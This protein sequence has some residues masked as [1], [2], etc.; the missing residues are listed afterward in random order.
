MAALDDDHLVVRVVYTGPPQAGKTQSVRALMPLLRGKGANHAVMSPGEWRGRTAFFDWADYE[1][2]VYD[3]KPIRCQILSTPGQVALSDRRELLLRA[4]D[5]VILVVDSRQ[6]AIERAT[7]CY[8]E[9]APWLADAGRDEPIRVILQCN[10][11][12][13]PGA[14][15]AADLSR[16][17]GVPCGKDVYATSA[18][19][20]K[21]LRAAFVAGVRNAVDRARALVARGIPLQPPEVL[22][23]QELFERMR[24]KVAPIGAHVPANARVAARSAAGVAGAAA[25]QAAAAASASTST[26]GSRASKRPSGTHAAPAW[27]WASDSEPPS[28]V[29]RQSARPSRSGSFPASGSLRPRASDPAPG[30]AARVPSTP[31]TSPPTPASASPA[32]TPKRSGTSAVPRPQP[33]KPNPTRASD[34]RARSSKEAPAPLEPS[35]A[36]TSRVAAAPLRPRNAKLSREPPA[37]HRSA[38]T[39]AAQNHSLAAELAAPQSHSLAAK[40]PV[41]RDHSPA[42]RAPVSPGQSLAAKAAHGASAQPVSR[43][44]PAS[45]ASPAPAR[46]GMAEARAPSAPLP[47]AVA[48]ARTESATLPVPVHDSEPASSGRRAPPPSS[49][50][51]QPESEAHPTVAASARALPR[52]VVGGVRPAVM[53]A[54]AYFAALARSASDAGEAQRE[55]APGASHD[56]GAPS[57]QGPG[58]AP[59]RAARP[60]RVLLGATPSAAA[61]TASRAGAALTSSARPAVIPASAWHAAVRAAR[62]IERQPLEHPLAAEPPAEGALSP[63][64]GD[65]R[66]PPESR[67]PRVVD[68]SMFGL[69]TSVFVDDPSE[70][71]RIPETPPGLQALIAAGR[72]DGA[73]S[74]H[75][76][77]NLSHID[78]EPGQT[79]PPTSGPPDDTANA[80]H[81]ANARN[82]ADGNPRQREAA[83][84]PGVHGGGSSSAPLLSVHAALAAT[85]SEETPG[86][87]FPGPR[88]PGQNRQPRA[89]WRRV[90]WRLLENQITAYASALQD[91]RGRWLGELAPGWFARTLRNAQAERAARRAFAE[92]VLRERRL[93]PHLSR[94]RCVLLTE[95]AEGFWIWQVAC[96]VPTLATVLRPRLAA[97][98]PPGE[99]ANALLD[100]ALGYFD[101]HQRFVAAQVPLPLSPHALSFQDGRVVYSGLLPDPGAVFVAPPGDGYGAFYDALRKLWPETT[102]DAAAVLCELESKAMGR[103]PEPLLERIRSV[104]G[105]QRRAS[106]ERGVSG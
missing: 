20:G 2:G 14:L 74:S 31:R 15:P 29:P 6:D 40:A 34:T 19:A 45:A 8:E 86:F 9:M 53:P 56:A 7:Q 93:A 58:A 12:D 47:S 84:E 24:R 65:T 72:H 102:V 36:A 80:S 81:A 35:E 44:P 18:T 98:E 54:S 103:L 67:P 59:D 50:A 90:C 79:P 60:Q 13:L 83:P 21:G 4:A 11:Q 25:S 28:A 3:G 17:L 23:G 61:D 71:F 39:S 70:S 52:S 75:A 85:A 51:R 42:A 41:S 5:A 33:S 62:D 66:L 43:R 46:S 16:V 100:A 87:S 77:T 105:G 26:A 95:E 82:T 32:G 96:R 76:P 68:P 27:P 38:P 99:M 22:D 94:P 37:S 48:A 104:V 89:V 97:G 91:A 63:P 73:S 101:A 30:A 88:L 57:P 78:R 92:Q 55:S 64:A 10:K 49:P 106:E 69:E 1:G